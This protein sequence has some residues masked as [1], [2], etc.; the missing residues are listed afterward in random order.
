MKIS[1]SWI[2]YGKAK[3]SS[4]WRGKKYSSSLDDWIIR[5]FLEVTSWVL[6]GFSVRVCKGGLGSWQSFQEESSCRTCRGGEHVIS[7]KIDCCG[8]QRNI[9][10]FIKCLWQRAMSSVENKLISIFFV[11]KII[12]C[13][14]YTYTSIYE[15]RIQEFTNIIVTRMRN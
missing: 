4:F 5:Q 7:G 6:D 11:N 13:R 12:V 14:I 10:C 15:L 8:N 1:R 9:R 2:L 3:L